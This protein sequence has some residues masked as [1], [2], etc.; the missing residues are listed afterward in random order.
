MKITKTIVAAAVSV[1]LCSGAAMA[2]DN[3]ARL[4]EIKEQIAQLESELALLEGTESSDCSVEI[5]GVTY[6][7]SKNVLFQSKDKEFILIYFDMQNDSDH[8]IYPAENLRLVA[9][10]N[11][12][13]LQPYGIAD[14]TVEYQGNTT[15]Q[16]QSGYGIGFFEAFAIDSHDDVTI[17][18]SDLHET[19]PLE[20]TFEVTE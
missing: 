14:P 10:Q 15:K 12:I 16:V 9:F 20:F 7:Y 1:L 4:A 3:S 18:M 11:G 8:T 13:S 6:T 5:D 17:V 19:N 2:E